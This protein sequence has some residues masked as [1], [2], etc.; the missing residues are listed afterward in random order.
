ML[1]S[2]IR[3]RTENFWKFLRP[4]EKSCFQTDWPSGAVV[5]FAQAWVEMHQ[6]LV[7][8]G[9]GMTLHRLERY[10]NPLKLVSLGGFSVRCIKLVIINTYTNIYPSYILH[11]S[12]IKKI[13]QFH[14]FLTYII[15]L[16]NMTIH[17]ICCFCELNFH[18]AKGRYQR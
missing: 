5:S 8:L 3:N 2:K 11:H 14:Y 7:V 9:V 1:L 4:T 17:Q 18:T 15:S 12:T 10:I 13:W 6:F 16:I